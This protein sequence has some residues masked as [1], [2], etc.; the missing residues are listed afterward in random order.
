[1]NFMAVYRANLSYGR[2]TVVFALTEII[3]ILLLCTV[4]ALGA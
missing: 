2:G 4:I 1:M 3:R